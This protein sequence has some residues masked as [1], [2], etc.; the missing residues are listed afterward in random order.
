[1]ILSME[2]RLYDPITKEDR[3]KA[4]RIETLED[5]QRKKIY[6]DKKASTD[7]MNIWIAKEYGSFYFIIF[8]MLK[9]DLKKQYIIR[10]LYLCTFMTYDGL[11][12]WGNAKESE[13]YMTEKDLQEILNLGATET[14]KTKIAL[15]Y[16]KLIFINKVGNLQVNDKFCFKGVVPN[17]YKKSSKIRIFEDAVRNL[18][19]KSISN[20]HKKLALLVMLLP[21]INIHNN[22]LCHNPLCTMEFQLD[23]IDLKKLCILVEYSDDNKGR[24]KKD[25][26]GLRVGNE[27]VVMFNETDK[28]RS[29]TINPRVY[30]GGNVEDFKTLQGIAAYFD[31]ASRL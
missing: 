8:K 29:I 31:L 27:Q 10:F 13:R 19:E 20:E 18:Y 15:L 4:P 3:G 7:E 1:M 30:F 23:I 5:K 24:L 16:N 12:L 21:Y 9:K 26:K 28:S 11:L 2:L 25:L 14:N 6:S 22:I 17:I